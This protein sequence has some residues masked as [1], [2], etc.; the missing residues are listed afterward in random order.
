MI[1]TG[2]KKGKNN[3]TDIYEYFSPKYYFEFSIHRISIKAFQSNE[4]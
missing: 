3:Y 2:S 4:K 1:I